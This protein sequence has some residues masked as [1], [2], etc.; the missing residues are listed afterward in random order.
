MGRK[1]F[2]LV[3]LLVVIAILSILASLLLPMLATVMEKARGI[4]CQNNLRQTGFS[5]LSYSNDNSGYII[6]LHPRPDISGNNGHWFVQL[7][8]LGYFDPADPAYQSYWV[9]RPDKGIQILLCPSLHPL[10]G[11]GM[12]CYMMNREK[13]H[14]LISPN[15]WWKLMRLSP[16]IMYLMGGD[17]T[18][19]GYPQ[20]YHCYKSLTSS[21]AGTAIGSIHGGGTN[22][23]FLDNS[24]RHDKQINIYGNSELWGN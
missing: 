4:A 15:V 11:T 5:A 16:K 24:V 3:E 14:P 21:G 22:M 1:S 17:H 19:P 12:P 6:P 10:Y 23:L 8:R 2:T 9:G 20:A 7:K 13:W 18:T